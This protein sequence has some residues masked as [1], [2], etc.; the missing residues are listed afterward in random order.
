MRIGFIICLTSVGI[1]SALLSY[2]SFG[3]N[4]GHEVRIAQ[5][6]DRRIQMEKEIRRYISAGKKA[7]RNRRYDEAL[8][9]FSKILKI[10]PNHLQAV[11]GLKK[12]RKAMERA[13]L[14]AEAKQ[15][16]KAQA[17]RLLAVKSA[18]RNANLFL[19]YRYAKYSQVQKVYK[20]LVRLGFKPVKVRT[21]LEADVLRT[22]LYNHR[23]RIVA[24]WLR[25]KIEGL[26][27]LRLTRDNSF[28]GI[29]VNL[30]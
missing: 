8:S 11:R 30:Y 25:K 5:T 29:I 21:A 28:N 12:V 15:R 26:L 10:W 22:I 14:R 1:F 27:N 18:L 19:H 23:Y 6:V 24:S 2:S 16:E 9:S 13:R 4:Y 17:R 7:L 3:Q 20:I